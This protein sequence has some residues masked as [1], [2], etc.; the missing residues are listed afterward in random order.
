MADKLKDDANANRDDFKHY[1]WLP[2]SLLALLNF[3]W[4]IERPGKRLRASARS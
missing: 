2:L 1:G 4:V 3:E